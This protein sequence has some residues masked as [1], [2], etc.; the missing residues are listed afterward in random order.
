[1]NKS[2]PIHRAIAAS[3]LTVAVSASMLAGTTFAWFTDT[4][5]VGVNVIQAG[6]LDVVLEDA[7]GNAISD[8]NLVWQKAAGHEDEQVLWEP[9][10]SY[11]LEPVTIRNN[12]DLAL[13]YK[14]VITGI[15][16]DA[17]LNEVIDWTITCSSEEADA[18]LATQSTGLDSDYFL[19]PGESNILTI[20]GKMRNDAG[21]EY[22]GLKIDGISITVLATQNTV[23]SDSSNNTYD[24]N[25]QYPD[26]VYA[27][28]GTQAQFNSALGVAI[29]PDGN[30]AKRVYLDLASNKDFT[31]DSNI[32][33]GPV[34]ARDVIIHG[35]NTQVIDTITNSVTSYEGT[36]NYQRNSSFR[37]EN[38]TVE[39]GD[40][41][42]CGIVCDEV[43]FVNCTIK[44]RI[45]LYGKATFIDCTFENDMADEYSI[46]TW[47]SDEV[48]V[49]NCIFNTNGK[50]ILLYGYGPTKLT[51]DGCTFNDSLSGGANKAAIE[52]GNDYDATYELIIKN[53]TVNGYS[54]TANSDKADNIPTGTNI[55][56]NKNGMDKD[57]LSVTI[58]G[59]A[60]IT[61]IRQ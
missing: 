11:D 1:M 42:Y 23:E 18:H 44:G 51:V 22:Q 33:N 4:A 10:S 8:R 50:A 57:H 25:A 17:Q 6:K 56:S 34:K 9:G 45:T 35:D 29:S 20:S 27:V 13:K 26:T 3:A 16:G 14:I 47:G 5:S 19:L 38:V 15:A 60:Q 54:S 37:F 7:A 53:I 48:L 24:Q 21:D 12:G 41:N 40:G 28:P 32:V 39:F 49:Q 61:G 46:W 59:A 31:L 36:L 2:K 30:A 52:I 43:T 58:D 55:W